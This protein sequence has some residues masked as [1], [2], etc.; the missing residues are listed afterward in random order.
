MDWS[1]LPWDQGLAVVF[2]LVLL[3][4]LY[5]LVYK[6]IPRGFRDLRRGIRFQRIELTK[7]MQ[8]NTE[9]IDLLREEVI[10][11]EDMQLEQAESRKDRD[12]Q[13]ERTRLKRKRPRRKTR[14][15]ESR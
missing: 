8:E 4:M 9:A 10:N 3:K 12:T 5:D 11:L 14:P 7:K 6:K 2:A 15:D 1:K 13:S